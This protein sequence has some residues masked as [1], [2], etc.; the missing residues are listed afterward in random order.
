[1]KHHRRPNLRLSSGRR[2][3]INR[4]VL[5]GLREYCVLVPV[6]RDEPLSVE[7]LDDFWVLAHRVG[8][9]AA[10]LRYGDPECY[11][12]IYNGARTR[13][14]SWPHFHILLAPS[15]A[16]KRRAM[17]FLSLKHVLRWRRWPVVR[18]LIGEP[19]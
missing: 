5:P 18:L 15:L 10:Q 17:F 11:S 3:A 14:M 1:M 9:R 12:V 8:R 6:D 19:V 13:R 2:C 4:P 16:A 7:E